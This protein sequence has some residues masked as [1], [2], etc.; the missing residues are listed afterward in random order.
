MTEKTEFIVIDAGDPL[1][2][3]VRASDRSVKMVN[4]GNKL[5]SLS[6]GKDPNGAPSVV[7]VFDV[8]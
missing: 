5:K 2:T 4:A 1:G 6:I 8:L 7:L 3:M